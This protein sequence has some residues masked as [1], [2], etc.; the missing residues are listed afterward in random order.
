MKG[1]VVARIVAVFV[2]L[3]MPLAFFFYYGIVK[4]PVIPPKLAVI[5]SSLTYFRM[6]DQLGDSV[7]VDDLKGY[8]WV[9]DFFFASCPGFCPKMNSKMEKLLNTKY[10]DGINS[11]NTQKNFKLVSFSVNPEADSV[12]VL[13]QYADKFHAPPNKWY[14]LS[15][16]KNVLKKLMM[17]DFR[18]PFEDLG[19]GPDAITHSDRLV[20][21]D[22]EGKYR[23]FYNV[24]DID[25]GEVNFERLMNDIQNVL[26]E[27][28]VKKQ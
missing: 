6:V 21:V 4:K 14:F 1:S 16:D 9:G 20:L 10:E 3:L 11:L 13:K 27:N 2:V 25:S 18:L 19:K 28:P 26:T 12:S 8:I 24:M 22:G 7:S 17:E 23:G 15:G 5:D